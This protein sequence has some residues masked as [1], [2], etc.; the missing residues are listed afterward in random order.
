MY[1]ACLNLIDRRHCTGCLSSIN[2]LDV[3]HLQIVSRLGRKSNQVLGGHLWHV[4][5]IQPR[6]RITVFQKVQCH[7]GNQ[8]TAAQIQ[9][10]QGCAT[11]N[12]RNATISD[13]LTR[14]QVQAAQLGQTLYNVPD[15]DVCDIS[16]TNTQRLQI[17]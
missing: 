5:Q 11:V 7:L 6:Q 13:A 17:T 1:I 14:R 16:T 12:L 3:S 10:D 9:F 8:L 2:Q 4:A 15:S